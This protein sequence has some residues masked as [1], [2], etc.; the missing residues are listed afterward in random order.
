MLWPIIFQCVGVW[1]STVLTLIK[2]FE[3]EVRP[4]TGHEGL[5]W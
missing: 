5:E 4:V 3:G 2:I 1:I